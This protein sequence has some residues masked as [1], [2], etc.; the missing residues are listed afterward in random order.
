MKRR[1]YENECLSNYYFGDKRLT[2]RALNIQD[3]LR[4]K[5]GQPL[6]KVFNNASD[7]KRTYEFLA[8]S[9]TS[10]QLVVEPSHHQTASYVKDL[11]II[12]SVGDTTFL[13][14][15]KIKVN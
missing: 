8:N 9:K 10:F 2:A 6:S 13:D 3:R 12:L 4:V 15:K 5:Y 7:L 14:Y 11:P 1:D